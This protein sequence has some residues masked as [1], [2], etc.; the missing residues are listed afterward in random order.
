MNKLIFDSSALLSYLADLPGGEIVEEW[1]NRLVGQ[2]EMKGW[3]SALAAGEV[4][5]MVMRRKNEQTALRALRAL[6]SLPV[7]IVPADLELSIEAAKLKATYAISYVDAFSA[8]LTIRE[9]GILLATDPIFDELK[10]VEF[11]EVQYL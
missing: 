7:Q 8:A 1:L 6:T 5:H 2:T 4:Y 3:V 10:G 9:K 11:F